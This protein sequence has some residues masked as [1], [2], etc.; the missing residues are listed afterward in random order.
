MKNFIPEEEYLNIIKKVPIFCIDFLFSYKNKFLLVKRTEQPLKNKFWV[1]GGR[2]KYKES[3]KEG[4]K[5]IQL[6]EIG[7]E[8]SNLRFITFSNLLF[9]Q[10]KD[11]RALHTP[12]ILFNIK[13][14]ECFKPNLDKTHLE[15]I[16]TENL[17]DEIKKYFNLENL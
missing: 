14:K 17:T 8:F 9:P 2:L 3:I 10:K 11:S 7:R 5:R 1:I 6:K 16:W 13:V 12:T 4:A 15:Y